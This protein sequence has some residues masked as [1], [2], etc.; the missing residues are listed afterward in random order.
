MTGEIMEETKDRLRQIYASALKLDIAPEEIG[1]TNLVS[2]LGIDSIT[3][4][5]IL[6]WVEDQFKIT[7]QDEDLSPAL[8]DSL[9]TLATYIEQ[10]QA[11]AV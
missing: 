4:L 2:T 3:S 9:D 1:D 5:E 8:L 7:I 6:V 11:S 10:H